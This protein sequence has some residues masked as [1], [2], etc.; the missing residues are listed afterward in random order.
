MNMS[1][2]SPKFD[3]SIRDLRQ[4]RGVTGDLVSRE[5]VRR[6]H[7]VPVNTSGRY[8]H[9]RMVLRAVAAM[10][11]E[12]RSFPRP[13]RPG[14]FGDPAVGGQSEGVL[15]AT[16]DVSRDPRADPGEKNRPVRA[17]SPRGTVAT[18]SPPSSAI[19]AISDYRPLAIYHRDQKYRYERGM[20]R[21]WVSVAPDP[22]STSSEEEMAD[23]IRFWN[24]QHG[25]SQ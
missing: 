22:R 19:Q 23:S 2:E 14:R 16:N 21:P 1:V 25:R 24:K 15:S 11:D 20:T 4:I 8:R 12:L 5:V 13:D 7:S 10:A 3:A 9:R 17:G 6:A 18:L